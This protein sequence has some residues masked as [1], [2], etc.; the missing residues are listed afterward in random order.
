MSSDS[1]IAGTVKHYERRQ[2]IL[3]YVVHDTTRSFTERHA[4]QTDYIRADPRLFLGGGGSTPSLIAITESTRETVSLPRLAMLS[5]QLHTANFILYLE[6]TASVFDVVS[7][8]RVGGARE[9][10]SGKLLPRRR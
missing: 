4:I 5:T 3:E 2:R 8:T 7:A 10:L 1:K 9:Q 6:I